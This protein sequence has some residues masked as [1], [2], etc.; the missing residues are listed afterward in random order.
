MRTS[1]A[2]ALGLLLTLA[3]AGPSAPAPLPPRDRS[4]GAEV[5]FD[6][7]RAG[8]VRPA[9]IYLR[10]TAV[11][12]GLAATPAVA[13]CLP[14][15]SAAER[16]AWVLGRLTVQAGPSGHLVTVRVAAGRGEDGLAIL[17]ALQ[18]AV[19]ASDRG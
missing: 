15:G 10:S 2:L 11:L 1:F 6:A 19:T 5:V 8:R 17:R 14:Q 16:R 9:R 12:D 3:P 13:R 4:A 18:K 7:G